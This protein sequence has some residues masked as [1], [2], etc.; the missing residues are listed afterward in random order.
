L[1]VNNT[2]RKAPMNLIPQTTKQTALANRLA[3]SILKLSPGLGEKSSEMAEALADSG[4]PPS[5]AV[6][7]IQA[8]YSP[9]DAGGRGQAS[10]AKWFLDAVQTRYRGRLDK[11]QTNAKYFRVFISEMEEVTEMRDTMNGEGYSFTFH[12][13][14][15]LWELG[16][17]ACSVLGIIQECCAG[18]VSQA[19]AKKMIVRAALAVNA[20]HFQQIETAIDSLRYGYQ[21]DRSDRQ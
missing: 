16:L 7:L 1:T 13:T 5:A 4:L 11:I 2:E 10:R 8:V 21:F 9:T 3:K 15:M 12:E 6:M 17:D 14:F 18:S 19:L 20:G